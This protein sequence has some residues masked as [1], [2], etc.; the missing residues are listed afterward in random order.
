MSQWPRLPQMKARHF[1]RHPE[2]PP[3]VRHLGPKS[4]QPHVQGA[5][6]EASGCERMLVS[7]WP[8]ARLSP[9]TP[10]LFPIRRLD[11]LRFCA[12]TPL[13]ILHNAAH[14]AAV[15]PPAFELRA[16]SQL[17]HSVRLAVEI[18]HHRKSQAA[19]AI[20]AEADLCRLGGRH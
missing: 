2:R 18:S 9:K 8:F 6:P 15:C 4:Q 3:S 5:R 10:Q 17:V 19:C 13:L 20:S 14:I 7:S 1:K 11:V 12:S 16:A